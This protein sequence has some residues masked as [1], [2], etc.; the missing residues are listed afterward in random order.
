MVKNNKKKAQKQT[1]NNKNGNDETKKDESG[2]GASKWKNK[3]R[4]LLVSSRGV[5]YLARHVILN[6]K[7]L[8]P[9][10]KTDS[11]FNR[12]NGLKE[13]SE[14]AEIRNCNK[15][16][17][18]EMHKKQDAFV[19]LSA[20][21][22][23]PSAKFSLENMHTMEELKLTGNCLKGSRPILSF[24]EQF[25]SAPHWKLLKELLTQVMG[26]PNHHPKSQP[27]VDH[28]FN[29][30]IVDNKIWFRNY[31][32]GDEAGTLAEIGPR[33]VLNPI[34]VFDGAFGG[35]C[36]YDNPHYVPPI[37]HRSL[38]RQRASIKYN[39][40]LAQKLSYESRMPKGDTFVVDPTDEIFKQ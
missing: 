17:Y 10:T 8:M 22:E 31:Q 21:P 1:N 13:L 6:L 12:K 28:V 2:I 18:V 32:I 7:T 35:I 19:W 27:F 30:S 29:F 37:V 25:D 15:C 36:L 5:S 26:T 20:T 33:L 38:V 11:K 3:Q 23:G 24:D 9:H 4:C 39:S 34:K 16:I 14:I 40:R